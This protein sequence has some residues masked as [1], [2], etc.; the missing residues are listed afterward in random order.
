MG[1]LVRP[2]AMAFLEILSAD[3]S[4]LIREFVERDALS[5]AM[6]TALR[7]GKF[8]AVSTQRM[9]RPFPVPTVGA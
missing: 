4:V 1:V 8:V 9:R 6:I 7:E 3:G 2:P 5:A